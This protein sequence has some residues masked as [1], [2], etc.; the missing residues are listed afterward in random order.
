MGW[1]SLNLLTIGATNIVVTV[2]SA[3]GSE[4]RAFP[5]NLCAKPDDWEFFDVAKAL[6]VRIGGWPEV[7]KSKSRDPE[8][9]PAMRLSAVDGAFIKHDYAGLR[10][11]CDDEAFRNIFGETGPGK[12]VV[13]RARATDAFTK[14][15]EIVFIQRD[16][17]NWGV[18]LPL[19]PEW[20]TIRVPVA[21]LRPYW[22]TRRD[23]GTKPDMSQ[24]QGFSS[25]T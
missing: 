3:D 20:Q 7:K 19:T 4:T 9:R 23:D 8:G 1:L 10:F 12:T 21:K 17:G 5:I 6:K 22:Q 25:R 13:F 14:R 2:Q 11:D 16:G 15:V 18:D 24:V